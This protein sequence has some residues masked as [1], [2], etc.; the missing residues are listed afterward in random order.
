MN[1]LEEFYKRAQTEC[2]Y[3]VA[4]DVIKYIK[5]SNGK[6][7]EFEALFSYANHLFIASG[8]NPVNREE[9]TL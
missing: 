7:N 5:G 9:V 6:S 8:Y 4:M 2:R 3:E 1:K